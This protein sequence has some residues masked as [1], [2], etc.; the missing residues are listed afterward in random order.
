MTPVTR[1][2][3]W[4]GPRNIS[5]AM[6]RAFENRP[7]CAVL[8]EPFYGAYLKATGKKHPGD[9]EII[10]SM[11]CDWQSV[12]HQLAGDVPGNKPV[13]YH[14]QMTHHMLM[15]ANLD[16]M[17][18]KVNCFLIR[19]PYEVVASY[20]EQ[21]GEMQAE[22][23]GFPQQQLLFER[24]LKT[25]GRIPAV[26]D[27]RDVLENPRGTLSALC[28]H[29]GIDFSEHMLQWPKG[30]RDTDGVW[31]KYWYKSVNESTSFGWDK[32]LSIATSA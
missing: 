29:I 7:D 2:E 32:K 15:D 11:D 14:K 8:D 28:E 16:W 5:T 27:C 6:L 31:A 12:R 30:S 9:Q 17:D 20:A 13:F 4:S 1:I 23:V 22:D 24:V 3:M 19:N 25:T 18:D 21:I 10:A 26:L